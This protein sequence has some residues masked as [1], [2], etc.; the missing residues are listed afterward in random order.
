MRMSVRWTVTGVFWISTCV[1][2]QGASFDAKTGVLTIPSV[3]VGSATYSVTLQLTDAA[4]HT[5]VLATATLN[6]PAASTLAQIQANV[7]TPQCASCH[8]GSQQPLTWPPAVPLNLTAGNSFANLVNVPSQEKPNLMLVKPGDPA[9]SY[10]IQKL[11]GP[12]AE[13]LLGM[14]PAG[15]LDQATIDQVR[16]WITSGAPNN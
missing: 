14:P 11:E 12:T 2:A 13:N 3:A 4:T 5:F 7:F 15:L 16:S 8:N 6:T 10:L 1:W 9:N